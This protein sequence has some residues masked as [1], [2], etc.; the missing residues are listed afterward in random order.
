MKN[1]VIAI[2][3]V[4]MSISPLNNTKASLTGEGQ[5]MADYTV[6]Q[7][8]LQIIEER[9]TS[10]LIKYRQ[11]LE[12]LRNEFSTADMP[13]VK[14]FLFGMGNR[15]K[16]LYKS[17][18]LINSITGKVVHEWQVKNET[19]I[20]ND[21]RVSIE[22]LSDV[23]VSIFENEKGVFINERGKETL[24]AGT[25]TPL[26]LPAF[27]KYRYSEVLKELHH[28]ILI[29][30]IDSKPVPNYFVYKNPWRRDGAMM[31]MCLK[32][33][34][35]LGLIRNWALSLNDPYDRNNA[36]ET[37]ADNLGQTLYILSFFTDKNHPLVAKILEETKKYE[38]QDGRGKYIKG[39]SDFHDAPVYQ[40]KWLKYGLKA[41]NLPDDYIIPQVQD[42]YSVLFWWDYKDSYMPGTIDTYNI[43][44]YPYLGWA[45]D[46]FHGK[47]TS[48]VSNR[49]YPLTWEIEASQAD[50]K[51]MAIIDEKYFIAKNSSP[52]TWHASEVFLYLLKIK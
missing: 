35:N 28:E 26:V 50:Y 42:D 40:T 29:N 6:L 39:R 46:N 14:F 4:C 3:I 5:S 1:A 43:D 34:G 13:D 10:S 36:G 18:K 27:E 37:E 12:Q 33:T 21:Y 2:S 8:G 38:V 7:D 48:P 9:V 24:I 15:T 51:G 41:L 30:I 47:K 49:D 20:P 32:E 19:I 23:T 31:A 16:L 44:K 52:H 45:C 17:G 22:T 11:Q 25:K